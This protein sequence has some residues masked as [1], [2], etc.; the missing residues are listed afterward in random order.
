MLPVKEATTLH[1][2][3]FVVVVTLALCSWSS[4]TGTK[5]TSVSS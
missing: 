4:A 2:F 5:C 1:L 3:F